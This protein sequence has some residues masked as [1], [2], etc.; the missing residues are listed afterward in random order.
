MITRSTTPADPTWDAFLAAVPGGSYAQSGS[1]AAF[2]KAEG[3]DCFRV[4]LHA[5]D[6]LVGGFQLLWRT[7]R[8]G[9]VGYLSKGPLL[10]PAAAA[11]DAVCGAELLA[12]VAQLRL[13]V[14]IAQAP[15]DAPHWIPFLQRRGFVA[16]NPL[17]LIEANAWI[18]LHGGIEAVR[19]RMHRSVR[20]NLRHARAAGVTIH[21]G[22]ADQLADFH[23]LLCLTCARRGERPHPARVESLQRLWHALQPHGH[24]RLTFAR[25]AGELTSGQLSLCF[26]R[27][28]TFYKKG[29]DG[30]HRSAHPNELLEDESLAW[31]CTHG[32]TTC[33]FSALELRR[34][35][36]LL[37]AA[38]SASP[39]AQDKDDFNLRFGA[40]PM[41]LAPAMVYCAHPLWRALGRLCLLPWSRAHPGTRGAA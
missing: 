27:R 14:L 16:A 2:K 29:W 5:A 38:P 22:G 25:C 37:H 13:R 34:A 20:K 3:W 4:Q 36:Q 40:Q 41:L 15:D 1:W 8:L 6:R 33:D 39:G 10:A 26:G 28:L 24:V 23:R 21:E 12:A 30:R 9:R 11:L 18:D 31:A 19:G 7:T 17:R 32:Y 35:R